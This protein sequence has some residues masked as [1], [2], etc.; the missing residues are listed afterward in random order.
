VTIGLRHSAAGRRTLTI[1]VALL[2]SALHPAGSGP[3]W[4]FS[5]S[6]SFAQHALA[7]ADPWPVVRRY[8]APEARQAVAVDATHFYAIDNRRIGKYEK[9]SGTKVAQWRDVVGGPFIHLNSGVVIDGRLYSAHSNYPGVPMVSSIEVWETATLRHVQ[10]IPVGT[11]RG[12][13]T[14]IDR[15]DDA[16]WV[17][18]AH[19]PAPSGEPGRGPE[20][21]VLVRYDT[22][23]RESGSWAFPRAVVARWDGMSSSGG[24]WTADGRLVTAGHHAP[25]LHI[26]RLPAAGATLVLES[27]VP[28]E[29]EG[30]GIALDP[31]DPTRFWSIQRRTAEVLVSSMR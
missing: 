3:V 2:P 13:A 11:G 31:S 20:Y 16:W 18:Y 25:E 1:A 10:T 27:I 30:Q 9:S 26:L 19:Y 21:S 15:Y 6:L 17:M 23:W 5:S 14:W 24:V 8:A 28:V 29:S 12:S 22:E 7:L 4:D